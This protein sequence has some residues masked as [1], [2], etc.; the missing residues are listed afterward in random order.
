MATKSKPPAKKAAKK[1]AKKAAKKQAKKA[2]KKQAK[3]LTL[4]QEAFKE[5]YI[6]NG[7]NGVRAA[8]DAGYQGN[9]N[10]LNQVA[11]DN[12]QKPTIQTA[13]QQRILDVV[14][15]D[16]DEVLR[17]FA[18][19]MRG[20]VADFEGLFLPDGRLDLAKAKE[21]GVSRLIKKLDYE[22]VSFIV[23][24]DLRQVVYYRC[25]IEMHDPQSA[26]S[27]LADIF[28]MKQQPR[29]NEADR[30]RKTQLY[31]RMIERVIQRTL[32]ERGETLG[33]PEAISLIAEY[34]PE[35][36]EYIH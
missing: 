1:P 28:G 15:A 18:A 34:Q 7:G 8:R 19:H 32:E 27:K 5:H 14:K 23:G 11:R 33:R 31:E 13:V 29:A 35:I 6:A 20:D 26:A 9:T 2:A 17:L 10:T 4:K 36:K 16:T 25:K 22:P 21:L 12:L 24:E 30:E 3:K